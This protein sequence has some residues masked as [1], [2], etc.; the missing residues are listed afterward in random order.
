VKD[1]QPNFWA[2]ADHALAYLARADRIPHR[3]EGE[4][5]LLEWLP[6]RVDRFLDLGSGDGRLAA[7]VRTV[8]PAAHVVALDFSALMLR[9]LQ[10]RF[11]S[12]ASA[13]VLAHSLDDPLPPL[14]RFDAVVSSF[15]IH[16]VSHDRKRA[17]YGEVHELL[18][19]GG[20]FCNLEHV[21]SPT[22]SLHLR[23]LAT[24]GIRPEDEDASNQLLDVE[25]QLAWMRAIGFEDVD[26]V[27][28]WM[29]LA[30]LV[31]RTPN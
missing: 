5:A 25:T 21:A 15:A 9:R 26:C 27:W 16:H 10:D 31:G 1:V 17:L 3:A 8:H 2:S 22:P 4:R 30:L 28:K 11:A 6:D 18:V 12:D 13:T 20:I 24:L 19:P 23:F 29:E 14:G 7:L